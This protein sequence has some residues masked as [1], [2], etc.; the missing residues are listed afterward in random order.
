MQESEI[1]AA[2]VLSLLDLAETASRAQDLPDLAEFF[3]H[4][5]ERLVHTPAAVLSDLP[6]R[7]PADVRKS[8]FSGKRRFWWGAMM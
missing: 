8:T 7:K 4:S 3:L 5:L 2:E 6:E 1:S